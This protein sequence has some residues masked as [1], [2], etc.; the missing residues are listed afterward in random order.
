MQKFKPPQA[1]SSSVFYSFTSQFF[2]LGCSLQKLNLNIL[3]NSNQE[4]QNN[5]AFAQIMLYYFKKPWHDL[6][7]GYLLTVKY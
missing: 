6:K 1:S 5:F 3:E 4:T 2:C 7:S